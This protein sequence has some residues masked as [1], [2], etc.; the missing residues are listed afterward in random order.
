MPCRTKEEVWSQETRGQ[1]VMV[2][3]DHWEE[4]EILKRALEFHKIGSWI[5]DSSQEEESNFISAFQKKQSPVELSYIHSSLLF[6][7][8]F[9]FMNWLQVVFPTEQTSFNFLWTELA[10]LAH[11]Y[12]KAFQSL[13]EP[14]VE[15]EN[16]SVGWCRKVDLQGECKK[17][18]RG[19][20]IATRMCP[21]CRSPKVS[22]D[23]V[24]CVCV[25]V[26]GGS[27]YQLDVWGSS[28]RSGPCQLT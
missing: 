3:E 19:Q 16:G 7:S 28:M 27:T 18:S 8:I 13:S 12:S 5:R 4:M 11:V 21:V 9:T 10:Y 25:S 24:V 2:T 22:E 15:V 26:C 17:K 23:S 1:V 6:E 14:D 20:D